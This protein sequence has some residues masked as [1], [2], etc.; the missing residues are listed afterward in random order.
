MDLAACYTGG[1]QFQVCDLHAVY[2]HEEMYKYT[3]NMVS[4]RC[5][6]ALVGQRVT[7]EQ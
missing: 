4:G 1:I 2:I 7:E 6:V 3:V 5:S